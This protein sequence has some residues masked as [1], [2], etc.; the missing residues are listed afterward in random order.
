MPVGE[1]LKQLV[2]SNII[3]LYLN[4]SLDSQ[5]CPRPDRAM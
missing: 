4:I 3:P 5:A 1:E 2:V